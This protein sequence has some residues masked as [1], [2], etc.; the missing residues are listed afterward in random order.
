[1]SLANHITPV[2]HE[3]MGWSVI[4]ETKRDG[5]TL[6]TISE[7]P[8]RYYASDKSKFNK[9]AAQSRYAPIPVP[10][11]CIAKVNGKP[12]PYIARLGDTV[13]FLSSGALRPAKY[14]HGDQMECTIEYG[15]NVDNTITLPPN[16]VARFV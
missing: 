2:Y 3:E 4:S 10:S 11:A 5:F 14:L 6:Y 12:V 13:F 8:K 16:E 15:E 1:M 9:L 7:N